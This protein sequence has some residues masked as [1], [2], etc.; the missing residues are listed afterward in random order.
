M[1]NKLILLES[2]KNRILEMHKNA[3]LKE[4]KNFLNEAADIT[5]IQQLLIDKKLMSPTLASGKTS[6]DGELGPVTLDAIY[7]ALTQTQGTQT[8]GG[9]N[10]GTNTEGG[11]NTS[12]TNTE[13]TNQT[14]GGPL[15]GLLISRVDNKTFKY[16]DTVPFE[17]NQGLKN[18]GKGNIT[19]TGFTG[20]DMKTDL[21]LPMTLPPGGSTGK[22]NI[23]LYLRQ[24]SFNPNQEY[25]SSAFLLTDGKKPNYQLYLRGNFKVT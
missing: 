4:N 15:T 17:F 2:E 22:F 5:Q 7:S 12:G 3:I 19:I 20:Y 16:G 8:Q 13:G 10:T 14:K 9:I 6:A 21:K 11:T 18:S 23:N 24:G 1:K 25:D